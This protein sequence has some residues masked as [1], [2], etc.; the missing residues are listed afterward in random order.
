LITL[1][2]DPGTG[3]LA[4]IGTTEISDDQAR[5]LEGGGVV[6][7]LASVR[8]GWEDEETPIHQT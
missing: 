3:S 6:G 5:M 1:R 4:L 2:G 7:Y 8:D